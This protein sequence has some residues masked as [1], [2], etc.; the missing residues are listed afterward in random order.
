MLYLLLPSPPPQTQILLSTVARIRGTLDI[1]RCSEYESSRR[2]RFK[3]WVI[4]LTANCF[5]QFML[6]YISYFLV[7]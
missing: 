6:M 5:T 4:I 3:I 1:Q 7:I 2:I